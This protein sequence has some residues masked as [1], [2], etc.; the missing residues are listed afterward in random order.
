[1]VK[2]LVTSVVVLIC[3]FLMALLLCL[4]VWVITRLLRFLFPQRFR[5]Q[6]PT[7]KKKKKPSPAVTEEDEE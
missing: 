2:F 5:S 4:M 6:A 3:L 7:K 1:M